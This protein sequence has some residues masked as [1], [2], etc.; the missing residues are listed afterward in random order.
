MD[1]CRRLALT[2]FRLVVLVAL[3]ATWP[4]LVAASDAAGGKK[5]RKGG[6]SVAAASQPA[7][8]KIH[9]N[10]HPIGRWYLTETKNFRIFHDQPWE[11]AERVARA[12]EQARTA[13]YKKWFGKTTPAWDLRCDIYLH[14]NCEEFTWETG[15]R[16]AVA[17]FARTRREGD[18]LVLRRVDLRCDEPDMCKAVLPHEVTHIVVGSEYVSDEVPHWVN[19]GIAVLAEPA[20]KI[21]RH[22]QSLPRYYRDGQLFKI[23]TL[24]QMTDYPEFAYLGVFYAQS[25]SL[26]RF[27]STAKR[28]EVLPHFLRDGAREG[29]AQALWR[30]YGW[31]FDELE[32]RWLRDTFGDRM[33]ATAE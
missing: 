12:A 23:R 10:G 15:Q 25:V 22:L 19:E 27:L 33:V 8:I 21:G 9:H 7:D 14:A 2:T 17:G 1:R 30:H 5:R 16:G 3:I 31:T 29:W 6:Q 24:L 4:G 28:P 20:S 26:V 13:A 18:R 32:D 11:L